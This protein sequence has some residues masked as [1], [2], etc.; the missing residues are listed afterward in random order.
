M[1]H[2]NKADRQARYHQKK[3]EDPEWWERLQATNREKHRRWYEANRERKQAENKTWDEANREK[4]RQYT[5]RYRER[6]PEAGADW[7]RRNK[8]EKDRKNREWR[9]KNPER[10]RLL[11]DTG[12]AKRR[13]LARESVERIV[14]L[15]IL[16]RDDG[17]CGI[18]GGD[19]DPQDF[20]ID[21]IVPVSK[22]GTHTYDNVQVAHPS[23]NSRKSAKLDFLLA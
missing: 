2:K 9:E 23:C 12:L 11:V 14:P 15:V 20:H 22:G 1:P 13:V 4:R 5:A 8:A 19:V 17:V 3:L 6:N 10:W 18:C 16:E 21:H 7:Y